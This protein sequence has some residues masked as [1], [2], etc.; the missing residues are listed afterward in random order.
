MADACCCGGTTTGACCIADACSILSEADCIASGGTYHGNGTVCTPNPCVGACC[1]GDGN[2]SIQTR[3]DCL[4]S[5]GNYYG[6]GTT[7]EAGIC[8]TNGC[9]LC[10][11]SCVDLTPTDCSNAGGLPKANACDS[12]NDN[13]FYPCCDKSIASISVSG[14]TTGSVHGTCCGTVVSTPMAEDFNCF[15]SQTWNACDGD[16]GAADL[17]GVGTIDKT[18][19]VFT[20]DCIT[21][22]RPPIDDGDSHCVDTPISDTGQI[23][24]TINSSTITVFWPV[25]AHCVYQGTG[26]C[27]N[28]GACGP[29]GTLSDSTAYLGAGTYNFSQSFVIGD[30]SCSLF[31]SIIVT[32]TAPA[33]SPCL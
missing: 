10:D 19:L 30:G 23:E 4:A 2:C 6:N 33:T 12:C 14:N 21:C 28:T 15:L 29:T 17:C 13:P 24:V 32:V 18:T 26:G 16:F 1:D 11:G 20:G 7:C 27:N 9:C 22:G 3:A 25:G 31:A 5:G 8:D